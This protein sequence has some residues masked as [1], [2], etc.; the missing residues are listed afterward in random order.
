MARAAHRAREWGLV[1]EIGPAEELD[2]VVHRTVES[3]LA[4]DRDALRM[5][6]ELLQLWEEQPLSAS[7][8]ASIDLFAEAYRRRSLR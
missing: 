5:Q 1:E 2:V 6:K 4:G 7:V 8:R 3:L